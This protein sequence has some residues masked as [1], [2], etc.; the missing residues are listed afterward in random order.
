MRLVFVDRVP[1][2]D[3]AISWSRRP[4][5][6]FEV[7]CSLLGGGEIRHHPIRDHRPHPSASQF[8]ILPTELTLQVGNVLFR[9]C[10]FG[11][12]TITIPGIMFEPGK[13]LVL[14][15]EQPLRRANSGGQPF[16]VSGALLQRR[17]FLIFG[18]QLSVS[19]GQL[20][21]QSILVARGVPKLQPVRGRA[22]SV[23]S[24]VR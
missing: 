3:R 19:V 12:K 18:G 21:G 11:R 10:Q 23:G 24:P 13:L 20:A 1:H 5:S 7:R 6:F 17:Q 15:R 2:A 16:L 8:L 22:D 9:L 4:I 14:R